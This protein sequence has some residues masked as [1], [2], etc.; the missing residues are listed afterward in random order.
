MKRRDDGRELTAG[1]MT[2]HGDLRAL[3]L[4]GNR[5]G[6]ADAVARDAGVSCKAF[7]PVAGDPMIERVLQVLL[8][9]PQVGRIDVALPHQTTI[10]NEAPRLSEWSQQGQVYLHEAGVSP[11][12]TVMNALQ[13]WPDD[14][15]VLVTTVDHALLNH[16]IL[17][18]FLSRRDTPAADLLAGLLPLNI[19]EARY[20]D[21][22]RTGLKLRDGRFCGCN[23]FL[24]RNGHRA[25]SAV[26][27]WRRLETLRKSPWR[28]AFAAGPTALIS[29]G[30]RL[31]TLSQT[32]GRIGKRTGAKLAP[33][34]LDIPEAAIDVDTPQD[35]A[36][37]DN[38]LKIGD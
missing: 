14:A 16:A 25:R 7:A 17:D 34:I 9:Y 31:L 29:H 2:S 4:A 21:V 27:F 6:E 23:L 12:L 18:Q 35:L 36:F 33:V 10:A 26:S 38:I 13:Q 19:L 30:L 11:A 28:M 20:P 37:V 3:V 15:L 22:K 1:A 24:V 5:R 32:V 8:G